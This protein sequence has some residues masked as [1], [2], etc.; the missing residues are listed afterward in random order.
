MIPER[1]YK[2]QDTKTETEIPKPLHVHDV[3]RWLSRPSR[4]LNGE[5]PSHPARGRHAR[6]CAFARPHRHLRHRHRHAQRLR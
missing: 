1:K 5:V 4:H 3:S 6:L 2:V